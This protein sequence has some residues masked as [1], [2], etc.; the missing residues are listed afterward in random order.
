MKKS[1]SQDP[2][3]SHT[4]RFKDRPEAELNIPVEAKALID[5]RFP[6]MVRMFQQYDE[7][8]GMLEMYRITR[9]AAKLAGWPDSEAYL[10]RDYILGKINRAKVRPF[11]GDN[12]FKIESV[13]PTD[14][15]KALLEN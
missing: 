1:T 4:L 11:P 8:T 15:V 12:V 6:E 10:I 5:Q 13:S 2:H 14:V 7:G 3:P 9:D